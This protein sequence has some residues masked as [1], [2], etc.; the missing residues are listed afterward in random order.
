MLM[1]SLTDL[2]TIQHLLHQARLHPT[3]SAGQ[4]F[5]ICQEVVEAILVTAQGGPKQVTELGAGL[6]TL[7]QALAAHDFHIQAIERDKALA[8]ILKSVIPAKQRDRV[9]LTVNDLRQVKWEW[10]KPYQLIGNIPYNLSGLILR[11]ITQLSPAPQQVILLVQKEVGQRMV[12]QPPDINMLGLAIQLWGEPHPLLAVPAS[13]F[14]PAPQVDSQLVLLLP[15]R[16][17][18][19]PLAQREEILQIAK[20]FFQ[21]KRKQIGGVL[22]RNFNIEPA[23]WLEKINLRPTQRPQELSLQNW[24]DLTLEIQKQRDILK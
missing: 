6:G 10:P 24:Q 18:R 21:T 11:R 16:E 19:R 2:D 3:R 13:C 12:A 5:L 14:W 4:N 7:T 23:A 9:E 22:Q 15:N 1:G 17:T 8:E 20:T